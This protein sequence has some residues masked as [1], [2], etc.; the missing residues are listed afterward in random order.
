VTA[1]GRE[2]WLKLCKQ[3]RHRNLKFEVWLEIKDQDNNI[4]NLPA[5]LR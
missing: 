3:A 1:G 4:A 5:H 2:P